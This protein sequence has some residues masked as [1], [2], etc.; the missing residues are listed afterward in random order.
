MQ[1]MA[2][3]FE[4]GLPDCPVT[5][6]LLKSDVAAEKHSHKSSEDHTKKSNGESTLSEAEQK[7][8]DYESL[9]D[10]EKRRRNERAALIDSILRSDGAE[11]ET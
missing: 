4:Q 3:Q 2:L 7:K 8:R 11:P 6:S 10:M 9:A 5:V 1:D